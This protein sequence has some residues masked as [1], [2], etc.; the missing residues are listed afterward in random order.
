[1]S[2]SILPVPVKLYT[3]QLFIPNIIMEKNKFYIVSFSVLLLQRATTFVKDIHFVFKHSCNFLKRL[4]IELFDFAVQCSFRNTQFICGSV[5][6]C[7]S[8]DFLIISIS[9]VLNVTFLLP[10]W[11]LQKDN[12]PHVLDNALH[13]SVL[14]RLTMNQV[15]PQNRSHYRFL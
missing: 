15:L 5:Y 8:N 1:V 12:Y 4:Q 7:F 3:E 10:R 2:A 14:L 6:L 13:Y 9:F 11:F